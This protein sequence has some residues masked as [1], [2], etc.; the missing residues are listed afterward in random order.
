MCAE[1]N[2]GFELGWEL[3]LEYWGDFWK[4]FDDDFELGES[5]CEDGVVVAC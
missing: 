5:G 2:A 4:V 1:G 3:F